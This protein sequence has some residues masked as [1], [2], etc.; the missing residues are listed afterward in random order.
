MGTHDYEDDSRNEDILVSVN[1]DIVH[2]QE[3]KVSVFDSCWAME[4]G[5]RSGC[6]MEPSYLP[7]TIWTG[8]SVGPSRF[9]STLACRARRYWNRWIV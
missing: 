7:R 1:G 3:A 9:P 4:S 8:Y 5:S 6:T 2:R